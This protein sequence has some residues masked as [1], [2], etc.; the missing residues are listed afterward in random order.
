[1]IKFY[2]INGTLIPIEKAVIKVNDLALL[3]GYG[4]FDFFKIYKG[5]PVFLEDHLDRFNNSAHY[6]NLEIPFTRE[7]LISKIEEVISSNNMESGGIR[8]ILTGGYSS[9]G[10]LPGIPNLLIL[11]HPLPVYPDHFYTRGVKLITHQY[12]RE[13]P[14]TKTTNY[15]IPIKLQREIATAEAIDVLYHDGSFISESS[16][17]NFFIVN[18]QGTIITS[19]KDAL[20]G[21]TRK[22]VL[23]VAQKHFEVT[24]R[25]IAI[26][27][28]QEAREA[29]ITS[30][31]KGIMPVRQVDFWRINKGV[32]GTTTR[33]LMGLL[34]QQIE[35]YLM[36]KV[37]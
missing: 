11:A 3:R 1:M 15:L 28:A 36:E 16:R 9:N 7:Q 31:T 2:S 14:Y 37:P 34:K 35:D 8:L 30:T 5:K 23:K 19:D 4:A 25:P 17:S 32:I 6:L 12:V 33:R 10:F 27:E 22:N 21:I 24:I 18:Q 26:K 13:T 29:F 20:E